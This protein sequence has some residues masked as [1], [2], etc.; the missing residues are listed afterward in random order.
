[1][2]KEIKRMKLYTIIV[3]NKRENNNIKI[4]KKLILI[5]DIQ[6]NYLKLDNSKVIFYLHFWF[7]FNQK[8]L[9]FIL[10]LILNTFFN[11][12]FIYNKF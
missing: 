1:M 4:I 9:R 5:F 2:I 6:R 11:S 10:K 12:I 7:F 8:F 3:R